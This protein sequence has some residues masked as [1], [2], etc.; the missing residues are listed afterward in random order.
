MHHLGPKNKHTSAGKSN[1]DTYVTTTFLGTLAGLSIGRA[2]IYTKNLPL[3]ALCAVGTLLSIGG[4]AAE[5]IK[6]LDVEPQI[7]QNT[8]DDL[9]NTAEGVLNKTL[10]LTD[11]FD[12]EA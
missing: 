11:N 10:G 4:I 2:P 7:L 3:F 8:T 1:V 6:N 12:I 5:E 9:F